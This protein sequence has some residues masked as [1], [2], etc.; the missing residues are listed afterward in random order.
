MSA[1]KPYTVDRRF[2]RGPFLKDS[3]IAVSAE[4][5]NWC[6]TWVSGDRLVV[7]ADRTEDVEITAPGYETVAIALPA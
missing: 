2:L 5:D 3:G 7:V 4:A 1:I 6:R